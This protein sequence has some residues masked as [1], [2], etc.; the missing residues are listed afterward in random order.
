MILECLN[1]MVLYSPASE[2]PPLTRSQHAISE[3]I[4]T[5]IH[6]LTHEGSVASPRL[7]LSPNLPLVL[8]FRIDQ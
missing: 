6:A 1:T 5:D 8:L 4:D 7:E 3:V 2:Y